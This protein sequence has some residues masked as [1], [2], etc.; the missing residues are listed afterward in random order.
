MPR[1]SPGGE[2]P[3]SR[4]ASVLRFLTEIT[5]WVAA[6][7]ALAPYSPW[8][9]ALSVVVLIALPTIF[10]TP[11]DKA[12]VIV[13]VPGPVTIALVILHQAVAAAASW[14]AW[15]PVAATAA[16]AV[17]LATTCTELPRWRA[18]LKAPSARTPS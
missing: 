12:H 4:V 10:A 15:P 16:T 9:A 13:P 5:A 3:D 6:P 8:L 2:I 1:T 7:W 18:L 17:A 11:G 14:A